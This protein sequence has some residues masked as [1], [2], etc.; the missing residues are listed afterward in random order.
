MLF[1]QSNILL[2]YSIG[3]KNIH[4]ESVTGMK[5][6]LGNKTRELTKDYK[7]N[8]ANKALVSNNIINQS[9]E[10]AGLKQA[11]SNGSG[12]P[13]KYLKS[14]TIKICNE[15]VSKQ[16]AIGYLENAS[17]QVRN[18][19]LGKSSLNQIN[20]KPNNLHSS[21]NMQKDINKSV[22][23]SYTIKTF[24]SDKP[25]LSSNL[26]ICKEAVCEK[27]AQK[28]SNAGDY[29][30]DKKRETINSLANKEKDISSHISNNNLNESNKNLKDKN[31]IHLEGW[32]EIM[33]PLVDTL[34]KRFVSLNGNELSLYE[35]D[36]QSR[37][38]SILH[39][40]GY[41][42]KD[43][44]I[45]IKKIC[46]ENY[47]YFNLFHI[48]EKTYTF[49]C[50]SLET[51][52]LWVENI[53]LAIGNA[54]FA[55]SY[56]L[57]DK[58]GTGAFGVVNKAV[59][60]K[61]KETYAVK[62]ITKANLTQADYFFIKGEIDV[63]RH[64]Q[65][66]NIVRLY[67]V[68]ETADEFYLVME[69][70]EGGNLFDFLERYQDCEV[71]EKTIAKITYQIA[72]AINYLNCYGVIHRDL[73]PENIMMTNKGDNIIAKIIDFGLTRV[74]SESETLCD[75]FGTICYAAPEVLL[76]NPYNRKIDVWSL[77]VILYFLLSKGNL[78]FEDDNDYDDN[79]DEMTIGK[80]ILFSDPPFYKNYF[81]NRSQSALRLVKD[82]L[83]KNP[84]KRISINDVMKHKWLT[85][86]FED[87]LN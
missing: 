70:L 77:G 68:F 10:Q 83:T 32:F 47:Y 44:Q 85:N 31:T 12:A 9:T 38:I 81:S 67:E 50:K 87:N 57:F 58:L 73:K 6:D 13:C 4:L 56:K 11:I 17:H 79:K 19:A 34:K 2:K 61:T 63:L 53:K 76:R 7:T 36:K 24:I 41:F 5:K 65:H 21:I 75:G 40:K 1:L 35:S 71:S 28:N 3:E 72:S 52:N 48:K 20:H 22:K 14:S 46:S 54:N 8:H 25:E 26:N 27:K 39:M 51:K 80:K 29:G 15:K 62:I 55:D 49:Y 18:Y 60:L 64:C 30:D 43:A 59:S 74:L 45:E 16:T 33:D 66:P 23:K 42:I 82:C 69:Y 86:T 78:P 37:L 84:E